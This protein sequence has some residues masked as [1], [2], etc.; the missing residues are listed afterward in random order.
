MVKKLFSILIVVALMIGAILPIIPVE[1]QP[2]TIA[3]SRTYSYPVANCVRQTNDGG[4][5][6]GGQNEVWKLDASGNITWQKTYG[7]TESERAY[8]IQKASDGG[9]LLSGET[10]SLSLAEI[11]VEAKPMGIASDCYRNAS[12]RQLAGDCFVY[13]RRICKEL[14]C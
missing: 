7:S 3:W 1:A 12:Q 2:G 5:I 13:F 14:D 6:G 8:S 4:Y 11:I 10:W 9:Y